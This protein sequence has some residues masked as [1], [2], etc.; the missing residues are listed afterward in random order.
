MSQPSM[1]FPFASNE[2][3]RLREVREVV[4]VVRRGDPVLEKVAERVRDLLDSPAAMVSVVESDHQ[5]FLARVGIDLDATPRDYSICSRTIMSDAP[6][7]LA[8]TL[9]APEFAAHPAV[10]QEPHVRF[11]VGAPIIL[12]SG[13]R[14]GSV[15]GLDVEPHDP[16]SPE[17]LEEL[18][19][20]A[21]E[22]AAYLEALYAE[23]GEGDT[24][25]RARIKTDAQR[26]FLSLVGH[27]FRTP[28]TVLLGNAQ[29]LRARLE[30]AMER[31][32]VEA[33]SASGRHLHNLIEH[34]IRYSNLES[35]E[36]TLSE[37]TVVC[38]DL[39]MAAATPVKPIA[40]ASDRQITTSC[41]ND[42][43]TV[44]AD[45]EQLCIALTSLIT[46]AVTHGEGAIEVSA[47]RCE[48][49]TLRMAVYDH[50]PGLAEGQLD[51]ADRPFTIGSHVDTRRK[52]GL[53]LGLPLAKRII[54]LHGGW[55]QSGRDDARSMVELRL[56]G[57]R[58]APSFA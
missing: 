27:E 17:T 12:S 43:T 8:N 55:M 25:R 46:N 3:A 49:E 7:V 37:E 54:Q 24:D 13:F 58:C 45:G 1:K 40:Q 42:V 51:K 23:R 53:G 50:G 26:E 18:V 36:L 30:G 31:R 22:T 34:V 5:R 44:R 14:V 41:A 47:H 15:C 32:M 4:G 38:D 56:P 11:Y 29:L 33:I 2:H 16:P 35:G 39:L 48:D 20:L 57:W 9:E 6:L 52:G 19:R 21:G 10:T 28:L